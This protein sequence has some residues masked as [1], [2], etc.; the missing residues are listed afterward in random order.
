MILYITVLSLAFYP[1]MAAHSRFGGS[2][3]GGRSSYGR[4]SS[5]R[6]RSSTFSNRSYSNSPLSI[7]R[8]FGS[9]SILNR[10]L[11]GGLHNKSFQNQHRYSA[12][13]RS[14][15]TGRYSSG[16][17][18]P[19][20]NRHYGSYRR[21]SYNSAY[22]SYPRRTYGYAYKN[23]PSYKYN[24]RTYSQP[25]YK[26]Y[27]KDR[28]YSKRY[29]PTHYRYHKK[30]H[31][32]RRYY[33]Y[34]LPY[35]YYYYPS[36]VV[37]EYHHY[38]PDSSYYSSTDQYQPDD[39]YQ[40]ESQYETQQQY[41]EQPPAD[42][43]QRLDRI[44]ESFASGDFFNAVYYSR[45]AAEQYPEDVPLKF[46][47]AQSLMADND[48]HRAAQALRQALDASDIENEGVFFPFGI[49]PNDQAL[50]A[51]IDK[52]KQKVG[53][54]PSNSSYQ[55]LL[56]YELLGT[57][58]SEDAKEALEKAKTN[59]ENEKYADMLLNILERS[60]ESISEDKYI[61]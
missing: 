39:S 53:Y 47:Y 43:D 37:Y 50:N 41:E 1:A 28:A 11:L 30:R 10:P 6:G 44:A 12:P 45:R 29:R 27:G 2:S 54:E 4:N 36:S 5:L 9:R 57:E 46:V 25:Y 60:K 31:Y 52:L 16:Y 7:H 17:Y 34:S 32:G 33:Y 55:L 24:N 13:N 14:Y 3:F 35:R 23:Y 61:K 58:Q 56:G 19:Y 40:S 38:N 21:P 8:G 59:L 20:T 18:R 51:H 49:Y 26:K 48:Y 15:G 42:I 22:R